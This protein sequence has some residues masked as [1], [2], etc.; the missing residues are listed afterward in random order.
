MPDNTVISA[1]GEA[2]ART[3]AVAMRKWGGVAS[4]LLAV[5]FFVAP[6]I[7][8]VGDLQNR[9]GPYAYD[10]ADFL[11]GPVWGASLVTAVFALRERIGERASRRM[12]LSL[13]A[14]VLS[15]GAIVSVACIRSANRHYHLMHPELELE[16]STTVLVAWATLVAGVTASGL[17]FLGW[18]LVLLG[19]AGWTTR[20]LPRVL[21][22]V[23]LVAGMAALFM[24]L[25]PNLEGLVVGLGLVWAIWQGILLWKPEAGEVQ[26]PDQI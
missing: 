2:N 11:Y 19:S 7:Y 3:S 12:T 1:H 14:A 15:A 24:Y 13:L 4:F 6:L 18:S 8:L 25:F 23:Y 5:T 22:V 16:T 26:A 9:I 10:L 17:H 21:C 20:S